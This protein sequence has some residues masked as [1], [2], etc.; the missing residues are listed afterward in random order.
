M[1]Y[2]RHNCDA[3]PL[4][5]LPSA[6]PR[7]RSRRSLVCVTFD[8]GYVDNL[9][10]ALPVLQHFGIPATFFLTIPWLGP[11]GEFWWDEL[12]R[13]LLQPG[14]LPPVLRLAGDADA[15]EWDLADAAQYT[16][17]E[18][19]E[20][21]DWRAWNH[22]PT[23][24]HVIYATLW[25]R[26]YSMTP[27]QRQLLLDEILEWAHAQRLERPSHR[28]MGRDDVTALSRNSLVEIGAHTVSHLALPLLPLARRKHE[29][30]VG[31]RSLAELV[32]RPVNS[33]AFPHG[34]CCP[35]TTRL[36]RKAG[37][38]RA[39]TTQP[40]AVGKYHDHLQL[41][42]FCVGDWTGDEFAEQIASW[43]QA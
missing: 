9:H 3:L 15:P 31:R 43:N 23:A 30:D 24:R 29:I 5:E 32:N 18:A 26:L 25:K 37:F 6:L 40:D 13:I 1:Q 22:P 38:L 36:V 12:D 33:F 35:A 11:P 28:R 42:R 20:N 17:R 7:R 39:C 8:D 14:T 10:E 16:R 27:E 34:H 41:P 4:A 2:V 21:R 19:E